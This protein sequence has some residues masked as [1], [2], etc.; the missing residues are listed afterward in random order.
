[1]F[2]FVFSC[3]YFQNTPPAATATTREAVSCALFLVFAVLVAAEQSQPKGQGLKRRKRLA[4]PHL[5][6]WKAGGTGRTN[7]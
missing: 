6:L 3:A 1:M 2:V 7:S 5:A 4:Q